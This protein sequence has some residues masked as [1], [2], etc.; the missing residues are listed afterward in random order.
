MCGYLELDRTDFQSLPGNRVL[1]RH[2]SDQTGN[3]FTSNQIQVVQK[4][5][6]CELPQSQTSPRLQNLSVNNN[7]TPNTWCVV[8][9]FVCLFA[10]LLP[11]AVTEDQL[12]NK[13]TSSNPEEGSNFQMFS[14]GQTSSVGFMH[15][16]VPSFFHI[17]VNQK[18]IAAFTLGLL[19]MAML[20]NA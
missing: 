16:I 4:S 19:T 6:S 10:L 14:T 13:C 2:A 12:A 11:T 17:S 15:M 7:K 1:S 3:V 20:Q 5:G 9:T 18:L 8:L